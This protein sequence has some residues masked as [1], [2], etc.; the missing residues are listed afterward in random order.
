MPDSNTFLSSLLK[1]GITDPTEYVRKRL[2]DG[3]G[4]SIKSLAKQESVTENTIRHHMRD[5]VKRIVY[6]RQDEELVIRKKRE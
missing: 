1:R 4:S 2:N 3:A 5:L 6:L